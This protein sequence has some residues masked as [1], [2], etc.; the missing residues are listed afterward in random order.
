MQCNSIKM[1]VK[2]IASGSKG[3]CT[4]VLCNKTNLIIDMGISYLTLKRSLEENSLSFEEFSGILVTHCHK[5]HT[6]GLSS[7]IKNTKLYVYIPEDMYHELKDMVPKERCIFIADN[8]NIKDVNIELIHTSHDTDCSVGYIIEYNKKTLVYVTDT[9]YINRKFL[10]KMTEKDMY[11]IESNHDEVMLMDGPYPRFLKERVISDK[12]HLS[13]K[14]TAK[15]LKKI[16]GKNTKNI[17]LAHLSEKNNTEQKAL[18][19]LEKE[20]GKTTINIGIA[21]QDE[22]SPLIEV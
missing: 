1:K 14:T 22:E 3:N 10:A 18:E 11:I 5:D 7:L 4:I 21:R 13:N 8:F 9:G 12:G 20:L 19:E 17:L 15:Y 6:K 16:I 2:T